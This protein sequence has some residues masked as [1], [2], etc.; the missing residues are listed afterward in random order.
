MCRRSRI[1]CSRIT[2]LIY[3]SRAQRKPQSVRSWISGHPYPSSYRAISYQQPA[4]ITSKPL[5][6]ITTLYA[7]STFFFTFY[8]EVEILIKLL[9]GP[10]PILTDL[11]PSVVDFFWP[12]EPDLSRFLGG[13]AYL[14]SL[15]LSGYSVSGLTKTT[16][17]CSES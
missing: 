10:F 3:E 9:E 7:K 5:S 17:A 12:F 4:S 1:L 6:R 16:L 11:A 13:S 15:T 8:H 2:T 14:R